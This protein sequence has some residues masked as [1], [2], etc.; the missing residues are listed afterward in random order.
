MKSMLAKV[1]LGQADAGFV[2]ATDARAGRRPRAS[3]RDPG[4][5]QPKVRYEYRRRL[6]SANR[7]A[8]RAF[9]EAHSGAGGRLLRNAGFGI[10]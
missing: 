7:A 4:R 1:A 8:A 5:A 10:R 3:D 9:V 6:E 2:Y